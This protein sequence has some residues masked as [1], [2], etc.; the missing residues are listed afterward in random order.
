MKIGDMARLAQTPVETIRYYEH[1][2]LLPQAPRSAG[3]YRIYSAEHVERLGFIRR[4]RS[5]DMTLDEI[6]VLLH[7]KDA[8]DADCGDVN[9]LLDT[10]IGH[11]AARIVELKQLE[12]QLKLLRAQCGVPRD[13]GHCGILAGLAQAAAPGSPAAVES[14]LPGHVRASHARRSRGAP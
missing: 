9:A 14:P 12:G 3:N 11:V 7:F 2:G 5:L 10:H 8:P 4:C 6:R 1:E 13:A